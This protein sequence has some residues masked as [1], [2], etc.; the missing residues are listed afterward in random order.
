MAQ[1]FAEWVQGV[2][3]VMLLAAGIGGVVVPILANRS[4]APPELLRAGAVWLF[5][6]VVIGIV[7]QWAGTEPRRLSFAR[8]TLRPQPSAFSLR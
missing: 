2:H 1:S 6:S 3:R 4:E 5:V 8:P 7:M